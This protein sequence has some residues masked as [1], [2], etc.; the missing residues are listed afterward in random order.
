MLGWLTVIPS[1]ILAIIIIIII[2][3]LIIINYMMLWLESIFHFDN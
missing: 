2:I 1:Y 3:I